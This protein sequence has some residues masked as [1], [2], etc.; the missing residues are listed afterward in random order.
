MA[1]QKVQMFELEQT[2]IIKE[3][4]KMAGDIH[5]SVGH[6]LTTALVQLEA[7]SVLMDK[8]AK[9]AKRRLKIIKE[10]IK[11]GLNELRNS[12][13]ELKDEN[14]VDFEDSLNDLC[15]RIESTTSIAV[16]ANFVQIDNIPVN[17]RKTI[18]NMCMEAMTNAIKHGKCNKI[19]LDISLKSNNIVVK[20]AN[21]G[22]IPEYVEP[23]FGLKKMKDRIEELNGLLK[24]YSS[25][26][27][28][29]IEANIPLNKELENNE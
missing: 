17:Y 9:Q 22:V 2:A 11:L 3:R 5:D 28:F 14:F 29:S 26:F 10:Q 15:K 21:A 12:I 16:V 19:V 25:S 13:R 20:I 23:G 4:N 7:V 8:D 27:G 24:N 18:Y 6:Q 1:Q